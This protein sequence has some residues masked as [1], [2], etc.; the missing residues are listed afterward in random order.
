MGTQTNAV[1]NYIEKKAPFAQELL[2]E[3]R[4]IIH[5][6]CPEVQETLKWGM[7]HFTYKNANLCHF[8]A[9][10]LHCS[11]GFWLHSEMKD[12]HSIFKREQEG[13]MGSLGKLT[14]L[15]DLPR[16]DHLGATILEAMALI[17]QGVKVKKNTS[18][19]NTEIT[20]PTILQKAFIT[21]PVAK[22]AFDNFSPSHKREYINWINDAKTEAT[23]LKRLDKTIANLLENKSMHQRYQK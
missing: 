22:S 12:H 6:F 15:E 7:P 5:D 3:L 8:A 19:N 13:G 10:K 17:E 4:S 14:K 11:F 21:F 9:F 2:T 1:S 20:V 23:L 18:V 16:R